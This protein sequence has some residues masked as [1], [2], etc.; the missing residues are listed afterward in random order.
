MK[1]TELRIIH[2]CRFRILRGLERMLA[3]QRDDRIQL[4]IDSLDPIEMRSNIPAPY[5]IDRK[6]CDDWA[7]A[8]LT[9]DLTM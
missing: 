8:P 9:I 2:D 6:P 4:W 5:Q 3:H 7:A 1:G